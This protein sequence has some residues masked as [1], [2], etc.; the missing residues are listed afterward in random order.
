MGERA[1]EDF[2]VHALALP[3]RPAARQVGQT[4]VDYMTL[5]VETYHTLEFD[6]AA[7]ARV[8]SGQPLTGVQGWVPEL[9]ER[10]VHTV[11]HVWLEIEDGDVTIQGRRATFEDVCSPNA[12]VDVDSDSIAREE[13]HPAY[14]ISGGAYRA[15]KDVWIIDR[16]TIETR[17]C[18]TKEPAGGR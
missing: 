18:R 12:T 4:I 10:G 14:V 11:G 16:F 7:M 2:G 5:R 6:L 15:A 3:E 17:D 8:A 13:A 1:E 9:E